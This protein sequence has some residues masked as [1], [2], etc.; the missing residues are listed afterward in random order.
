M[1]TNPWNVQDASMF[2]K[3]CCPECD[4][5]ITHL[6][7]FEVHAKDNHELSDA[8]FENIKNNDFKTDPAFQGYEEG[9]GVNK[10]DVKVEEGDNSENAIKEEFDNEDFDGDQGSIG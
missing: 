1:E 7:I 4:F 6:N 9:E 5:Q 2:L 3:Y 8:M 10:C